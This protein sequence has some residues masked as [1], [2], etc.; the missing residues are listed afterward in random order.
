MEKNEK[1][2]IAT[3]LE[4]FKNSKYFYSISGRHL[5]NN[6]NVDI[7]E[8]LKYTYYYINIPQISN[9]YGNVITNSELYGGRNYIKISSLTDEQIKLIYKNNIALSLTLS[10]HFFTEELYKKNLFLLEKYHKKGNSIICTS[11]DFAKLLRKDFPLYEIRA[12]LLKNINT[13]E[14]I[15]R[16]LEIYDKVV[17]PPNMYYESFLEKLPDKDKL[18]LFG[19]DYCVSTCNSRTCYVSFSKMNLNIEDN[20][21]MTSFNC[22]KGESRYANNIFKFFDVDKF[23]DMGYNN[24]K[25]IP[26]RFIKWQNNAEYVTIDGKNVYIKR[27]LF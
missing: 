13:I 27:K 18:I 26:F 3:N 20:Q 15:K 6:I 21:E 19:N 14:K 11:D 1:L 8:Q 17:I 22:S 24:F 7:I 23:Y 12:S 5:F 9:I 4:M 16:S 10:N 2:I 25:M